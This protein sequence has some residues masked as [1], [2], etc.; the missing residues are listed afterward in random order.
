[1]SSASSGG[2]D[3]NVRKKPFTPTP[4]QKEFLRNTKKQVLMSGSFGAGKSRIGCEKGYMLNL[5]YPGN[6]GLIVR[7]QYTDVWSSTIDQ[8]LLEEVIPESHIV[9]HNQTKHKITHF[10]GTRGPDKEPVTSEIQY[11]GLDAG[12]S[13]GLPT[14]IGGQ[15]YG[16]IFVDE[17]I[18]ISKSAWVQLLGRLR[19]TGKEMNGRRYEVPFRQIFTATN[20]AS[21][22]HWMYQ[23]FFNSEKDDAK[24]Y[25]MTAHELAKHVPTVPNDY[26]ETMESN[27]TGMYA[28]RYIHGEWVA[29]SGLVYNEY[30][31][32]IHLRPSQDLPGEW[33]VDSRIDHGEYETVLALPP[34]GWRVYRSIDFGYRNPFVCQWWARNPQTDKHVMFREVY[35]TEE[36]ME[37]LAVEIKRL[38]DGMRIEQSYADPA[39]AEDR[40]TLA[41]HGVETT[42]AKKDVSSGVQEVKGK[43]NTADDG[44]KLMFMS[45]ALAHAP[46]PNLND[47]GAPVKTVDEIRDYQWKDNKDAPEKED[48]HGMDT[49]RYYVHTVSQG[50]TWTQ[51]EMERLESM[52]N[53]DGGF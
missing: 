8:T 11:H 16:W 45:G 10:T 53:S 20:P 31:P 23:W 27:F 38:T 50:S 34:E 36:L 44:P 22:A 1:M 2:V 32:E 33:T 26:V 3:D 43:L 17:G 41:R 7:D 4:T 6:R 19:Y 21:K 40:A 51:D 39:S 12:G 5:K 35:R 28:D 24:A 48:D 15:Q 25:R 13:D 47:E 46:D 52:F 42:E 9:E 30:D 37:D 14:K 18:E 29:A 49:M